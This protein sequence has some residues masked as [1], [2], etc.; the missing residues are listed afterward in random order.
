MY[1][2][3]AA[4]TTF[5]WNICTFNIDEIDTRCQF[6]QRFY[7]RI[8]RT[9]V[10]SAAFSSY[11]LALAKNLY[12]NCANLML[13]KSTPVFHNVVF[14]SNAFKLELSLIFKPNK[15]VSNE[16]LIAEKN[17]NNI[18][19]YYVSILEPCLICSTLTY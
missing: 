16:L 13:M 2:K 10:V 14:F 8:F 4:E 19:S 18:F 1:V 6:H 15:F 9:N 5:L 11:V 17:T 3:K 7:V 12:K